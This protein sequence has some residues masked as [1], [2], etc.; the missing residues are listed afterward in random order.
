LSVYTVDPLTDR[1]WPTLVA[2]HPLA[3]VFHTREW[4]EALHRTYGYAPVAYTTSPPTDRLSNAIVLCEIRSWLTGR[5]LVS[6]PFADHC[7]PLVEHPADQDAIT[8]HLRRAVDSGAWKYA[9][10]RPRT[11]NLPDE[12]GMTPSGAFCVHSLDL[13]PALDVLFDRCHKDSIQRRIRRAER[14]T[15]CCETGTSEAHL[16]AFFSLLLMT[17]RRHRV[18]PQPFE[19]FRNL[20]EGM[21]NRLKICLASKGTRPV[22]GI[23]LFRHRDTLVYKYGA[24]DA[25]FHNLGAMPLL[26][27]NAIR[28]AK[29]TGIRRLDFGRPHSDNAGLITF[30]DRFGADR[31]TLTYFRYPPPGKVNAGSVL[32]MDAAKMVL[33]RLPDR[34]LVA[35]GRLLYRHIGCWITTFISLSAA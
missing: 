22:A 20:L 26:L 8:E 23:M 19:W 18:P 14:E 16:R 30:K 24:S 28:E 15:L 3:S 12:R 32:Q 4:L 31:S 25:R 9:E 21:G 5:R 17:R 6:L 33:A 29:A 7:Q 2:E 1:R 35:T 27:W 10:I 34:W 11:S 13:H